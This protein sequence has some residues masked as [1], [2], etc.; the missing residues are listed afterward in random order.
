MRTSRASEGSSTAPQPASTT[1]AA[2]RL[3]PRLSPSI[4]ALVARE[5]LLHQLCEGWGSPLN[6]LLPGELERNVTAFAHVF[7]VRGV[8]GKVFYAHKANR[9]ASLVR[10]AS[11]LRLGVDV[12]ST[13]ELRSAL[14]AGFTGSRIEATGPKDGR[15]ITL[16]LQ[17]GVTLNADSIDEVDRVAELAGRL[18]VRKPV[19]ILVRLS[20]FASARHR[21]LERP[22]RFGMA[23]GD[24]DRLLQ[25]L[26]HWKGT[27]DLLGVSCHL[28]SVNVLERAVAIE[29]SLGFVCAAREQ[30]LDPRVLN[31]G[32]GYKVDYLALPDHWHD[33]VTALKESVLGRHEPMTW[34]GHSFGLRAEQGV[35]RG[36]F[37]AYT[38]HDP[39]TGPAY[40]AALLDH[41]LDEHRG[42]SV[43]ETVRDLLLEL[44]VE[45]GRSLVDGCGVTVARVREVR[46]GR[47]GDW[48]VGLEMNRQDLAFS[49]QEMLVD[50]LVIRR[51]P[52]RPVPPGNAYLTGNLCMESDLVYRHRTHFDELP[53]VGDL[54]CFVNTAGY[55]MDFSATHAIQQPIAS[56]VAVYPSENGLEW[57]RDD[58]Y[59]PAVVRGA[60]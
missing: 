37:N 48:M 50:P 12:A 58:L 60:S 22:S 1:G 41:H 46:T 16:A 14:A 24:A 13:G 32:G 27:L 5:D 11:V 28:D 51:H 53:Q 19:P 45:P 40:L 18:G 36:H 30:G 49:E 54:L 4:E 33:Y 15:F 55:H 3:A 10:E 2:L 7:D 47:A 9:A 8:R 57:C 31:I 21:F 34:N 20:G 29:Q 35:L 44:W 39:L 23:A 6:L 42:A 52:A 25:R 17:H 56:K 26:R 38:Y 59:E 43:A